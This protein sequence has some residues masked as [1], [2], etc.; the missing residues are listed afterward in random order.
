M[1]RGVSG[2]RRVLVVAGLAA[3][4]PLASPAPGLAAD[5]AAHA[6]AASDPAVIEVV[7]LAFTP[8]DLTVDTGT[9]VT[10]SFQENG[11]DTAST[12]GFWDTELIEAGG[13]YDRV[14]SAGTYPYVCTPHATFM[15]GTVRVAP[16]RVSGS[17]TKGWRIRWGVGKGSVYDVQYKP[18]GGS[19]T[20][21]ARDTAALAT[22]VA[23][24]RAGSYLLRAR[25][26]TGV[27]TSSWSP[28]ISFKVR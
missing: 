8:N 21:F 11:H 1:S 24:K 6:A 4:L 20:W 22:K 13:S 12:Q 16:V 27:N 2:I 23:P 26:T 9:T 14:F 25:T 10:W 3:V 5:G 19:W 17:A 18:K 28:T 15:T 7:H